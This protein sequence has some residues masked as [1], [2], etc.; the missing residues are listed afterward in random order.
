MKSLQAVLTI[1]LLYFV[2]MADTQAG[3]LKDFEIDAT[4][5]STSDRSGS[6]QRSNRHRHRDSH[7][8][9]GD[10][11][12]SALFGDL[13]EAV[14]TEVVDTSADILGSAVSAGGTNSNERIDSHTADSNRRRL[15]EPL[16]PYFRLNLNL[17]NIT[18]NIYGFDGK[19]ELG[20]G[21]LAGEYRQT[22]Y[23][24]D[25]QK[26]QLKLKQFQFFYRMSFGNQV[27]VNFGLGSASLNGVNQSQGGMLSMP[28][29]YHP[30]RHLAFEFR[31]TWL[32][33]EISIDELDLSTLIAYKRMAFRIGYR[34]LNS[35]NESLQGAYA[36]IDYIF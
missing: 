17:Q 26:E 20:R 13:I 1:L 19:L 34:Q 5:E 14:V 22:S 16:I 36:G 3:D 24:D 15:G 29:I 6:R 35:A 7:H 4:Q 27:G 8:D 32:F 21:A 11:F 23:R 12:F 31:P 2:T 25:K 33:G 18:E 9:H 28:I 10:D 30:Q